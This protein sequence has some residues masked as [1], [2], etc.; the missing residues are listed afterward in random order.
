MSYVIAA[1]EMV[2]AAATDLARI[3]STISA[4]NAG[5]ALP[6][7]QLL[8]AGVDEVSEA[9]AGLFSGHGQTVSGVERSGGAFHNQFVQALSGG[10]A[11][12]RPRRRR[13]PRRWRRWCRVPRPWRCFRPLRRRRGAR[14]SATAP[15]GSGTGANGGNGRRRMVVGNGGNGGAGGSR[16][17]RRYRQERGHWRR[18]RRGRRGWRAAVFVWRSRRCR[19]GGRGRWRR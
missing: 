15:M 19:R 1:P 2:S 4:A 8:A 18:Q 13:V 10:G 14:C 11:R 12:I 9:V 16:R 5:A 3:G 17:D 6:T 7:T